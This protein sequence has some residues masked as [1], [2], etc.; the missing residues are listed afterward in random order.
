MCFHST[1]YV[2]NQ[3]KITECFLVLK[4]CALKVILYLGFPS[5]FS[6]IMLRLCC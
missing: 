2:K 6:K 5:R 1:T 3:F 4:V